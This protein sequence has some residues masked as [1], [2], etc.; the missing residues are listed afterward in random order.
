MLLLADYRKVVDFQCGICRTQRNPC[1]I[2]KTH[3]LKVNVLILAR[4]LYAR[5]RAKNP[6]AW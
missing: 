3:D 4:I 6:T 1:D 5:S 2:A